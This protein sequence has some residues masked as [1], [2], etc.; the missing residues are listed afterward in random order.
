MKQNGQ[1]GTT[2]EVDASI[3]FESGDEEA[4]TPLSNHGTDKIDATERVG[5]S[6]PTSVQEHPISDNISPSFSSQAVNPEAT[7]SLH[8]LQQ[9]RRSTRA[10]KP[11]DR[12]GFDKEKGHAAMERA[13]DKH[14]RKDLFQAPKVFEPKSYAEALKCSDRRKWLIAI[15]EE[16]CALIAN[17]TWE[18]CE[19][20]YDKNIVT[21]K[22]VFRIKYTHNNLIDRYKA[23]LVA[24]GFTQIFGVDYEE[25]FAPTLRPESLRM[26]ISFA[27]YFGLMI[28]QMDVPNAYL[29]GELEEEIYME[30][31]EGLT[32]P[33]GQMT[34]VLRLKKGLYGLKQSGRE[35]NKKI[36]K[37]LRSIGYLPISGDSCVFLNLVTNVII[38][39]YVDDLLIFSKSKA[40]IEEVKALLNQEYEKM[41]DLGPAQLILGI[42]IKR[43]G[44]QIILD[45]ST[46]IKNFLC[47]YQMDQANSVTTPLD[48]KEM[49]GPAAADELRT[50]Q[51]EYQKRVGSIMYAMTSTRPDLAYAVGKLS[52]HA[53]DPTIRHRTALDR[54]LKYLKGTAELAL[55][56]DHNE[57]GNPVGFADAAYGDDTNDRKSTH[58]YTLLLGNGAVIWSS[59]KQRSVAT[60]TMEAEYCSMCQAAKSIVWATRWMN[61][62]GFGEHMDLPIVLHGDNQGTLD[63][64]KNPEH[65]SKSRHM[66]IQLHY[67]REVVNDGYVATAHVSTRNMIADIFTKPLAAP[68][69]KELREK[70]GVKEVEVDRR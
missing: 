10:V 57:S 37:F 41:K 21:S 14:G 38:A 42:R 2:V 15:D 12:Y 25:T 11:Y 48:G 29:K 70:L 5:A 9:P 56:Y 19:R 64:V 52:Q 68:A 18:Y 65:H 26:L 6:Q 60:S 67:L 7:E 35:W 46:Y 50:D 16:L 54:V 3:N 8:S 45:Q 53:H 17:G 22:W 51:L 62:L 32:L 4:G 31:P 36:S 59:K 33:P 40:A 55:I 20:P 58:G 13:L 49:L 63:L 1:A 34:F 61:E 43:D 47:E 27:A 23:R 69:F 28:E 44:K 39:L 66:D 30:V 24:R